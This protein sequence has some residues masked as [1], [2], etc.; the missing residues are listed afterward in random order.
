M[1]EK[2]TYT[3]TNDT[4]RTH[5]NLPS[6]IQRRLALDGRRRRRLENLYS[7]F[8]AIEHPFS[9][10]TGKTG[11]P[12]LVWTADTAEEIHT[13]QNSI[14]TPTATTT[15]TTNTGVVDTT[16][17]TATGSAVAAVEYWLPHWP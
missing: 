1:K 8:W 7:W 2:N 6:H 10:H 17:A 13:S 15:T 9:I 12:T 16:A 3:D 4:T 14:C 11:P 5:T